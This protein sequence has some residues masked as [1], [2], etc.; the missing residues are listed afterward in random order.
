M[1]DRPPADAAVRLFT[2]DEAAAQLR[3]SRRTMQD[4]IR[5]HAFYRIVGRR[6]MFTASDLN[7]I[8]N[9]LAVCVPMRSRRARPTSRPCR[10]GSVLDE[11][12]E[13]ATARRRPEAR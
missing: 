2:M 3:V 8:V 11:A 12:L 4:I 10:A 6:K 13:L 7:A 1:A 5:Q 9:A